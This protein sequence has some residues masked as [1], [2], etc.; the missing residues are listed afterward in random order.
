LGIGLNKLR[1]IAK[2]VGRDYDVALFGTNATTK[3]DHD[4][5]QPT[6]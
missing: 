6:I 5:T 4:L 2:Q 1:A 3:Q